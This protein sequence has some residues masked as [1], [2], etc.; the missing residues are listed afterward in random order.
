LGIA[1]LALTT[2][3][4]FQAGFGLART[5]FIYV[6]LIALLSLFGSFSASIVLS[7]LAAACL[8]YFFA[9]PLF[10]FRIDLWQ[11]IER[12]AVFLTTAV[13]VTALTTRRK[14]AEEALAENRARLEKAQRLAHVGWWERDFST[15]H[16]TLSEEVSRI[17]GVQPVD[18]P[19]W[20]ARW[21]KLIHPEDRARV[22]LSHARNYLRTK[23]LGQYGFSI[24]RSTIPMSVNYTPIC[25]NVSVDHTFACKSTDSCRANA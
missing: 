2:F 9:P 5:A 15:G 18:L 3:I 4:C 1:G 22:G 6:I 12:I 11:D 7:L 14:R 23:E 16:V 17:F 8:N 10:E 24:L 25:A 13:V 19:E 20:H 21:L